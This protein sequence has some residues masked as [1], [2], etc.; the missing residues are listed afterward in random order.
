[1]AF[2]A[3]VVIK[4]FLLLLPTEISPARD[5]D[6][7]LRDDEQT[8][9]TCHSTSARN[10][11]LAPW[12]QAPTVAQGVLMRDLPSKDRVIVIFAMFTILLTP[13]RR[14]PLPRYTTTDAQA[15]HVT[16]HL[17]PEAHSAQWNHECGRL[18]ISSPRTFPLVQDLLWRTSQRK[19]WADRRQPLSEMLPYQL[20]DRVSS[21]IAAELHTTSSWATSARAVTSFLSIVQRGKVS[22]PV[23]CTNRTGSAGV[24]TWHPKK[25]FRNWSLA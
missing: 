18:P 15:L 5:G 13:T 24:V 23:P 8:I 11:F 10:I 17:P 2:L 19:H 16:G 22:Q 12:A 20:S 9:H 4:I 7:H 3:I 1:M 21:S 6:L 14:I 25:H